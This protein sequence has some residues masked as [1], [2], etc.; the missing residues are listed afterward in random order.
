MATLFV[1][2]A[3]FDVKPVEEREIGYNSL[4]SQPLDL[5]PVNSN[6]STGAGHQR[7]RSDHATEAAEDYV[8]AIDEIISAKGECRVDDLRKHFSVSHVTVSRTLSRLDRDGYVKKEAYRPVTLTKKGKRLAEQSRARHQI[9]LAFLKVLGVSEA[10]AELD[11][12]GIEHHVSEETLKIMQRFTENQ[13]AEKV[14]STRKVRSFFRPITWRP[15]RP[16]RPGVFRP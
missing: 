5:I 16:W 8:E 7:T 2:N 3:T 14:R 12:E 11:A 15:W 6:R 4:S 9:V 13:T 10:I 1:A